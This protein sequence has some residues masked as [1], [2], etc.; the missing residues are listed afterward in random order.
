MKVTLLKEGHIHKG[1][2]CKKGD[3]IEVTEAEA[4]WLADPKRG[5]IAP[6]SATPAPAPAT[7]EK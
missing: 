6:R 3:A 7:K 5:L 4:T 1:K 2:P